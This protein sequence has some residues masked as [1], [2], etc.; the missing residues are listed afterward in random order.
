MG[1]RVLLLLAMSLFALSD[2]RMKDPRDLTSSFGQT[3]TS[4]DVQRALED[5]E[6]FQREGKYAQSL[7]RH[8]WYHQ[9]A[10]KYAPAQSGVRLSF[11]LSDWAELGKVYPKALAA[12]R[13]TRDEA[14][15]T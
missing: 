3:Y 14:L 12:L 2:S 5:A 8:I 1:S 11:A 10:L 13:S 6:R 15:A 7:E 4:V 9:N